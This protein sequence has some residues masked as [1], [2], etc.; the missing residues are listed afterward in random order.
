MIPLKA[1]RD[2]K[3]EISSMGLKVHR[4]PYQSGYIFVAANNG[5]V[6]MSVSLNVTSE[7]MIS[8]RESMAM[9]DTIY[10][11]RGHLLAYILS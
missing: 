7:N 4:L 11:G 3:C 8:S 6:A 5:L 1:R 9:K 10:P 2:G